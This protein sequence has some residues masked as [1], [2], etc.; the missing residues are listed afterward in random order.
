[1]VMQAGGQ[2]LAMN[3]VAYLRG[4]ST[5]FVSLAKMMSAAFM[6]DILQLEIPGMTAA[7]NSVALTGLKNM[8]NDDYSAFVAKHDIQPNQE[9]TKDQ[10]MEL[11]VGGRGQMLER[12]AMEMPAKL[13]ALGAE[14]A[15]ANTEMFRKLQENMTGL[16]GG[17][18]VPVGQRMEDVRAAREKSE[19]EAQMKSLMT[20]TLRETVSKSDDGRSSVTRDR[21]Y[22]MTAAQAKNYKEGQALAGGV[23]VNIGTFNGTYADWEQTTRDIVENAGKPVYDGGA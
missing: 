22:Q 19:R 21:R 20:V 23:V 14:T 2:M 7:R 16:A 6:E 8:S 3:F 17:N 4:M 11:A 9:F 15:A 12:A 18:I 5:I 13:A 1:M 10:A